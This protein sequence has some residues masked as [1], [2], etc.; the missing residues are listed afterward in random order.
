MSK[1]SRR[2]FLKSG[3]LGATA[4]VIAPNSILGKSHGHVAPSDKLNIAGIGVGGVDRRFTEFNAK[5]AAEEWV[6]HTYHNGFT[7]PPMP[8]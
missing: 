4:F 7:L 5:E 8:K 2:D 6:K 1:I 3:A